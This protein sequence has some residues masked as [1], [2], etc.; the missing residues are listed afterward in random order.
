[1]AGGFEDF[2]EAGTVASPTDGGDFADFPEAGGTATTGDALTTTG[3][4]AVRGGLE[5]TG[6]IGGAMTGARLG[7][8]AAPFLGPLAPAAPIVGGVAGAAYGLYAGSEAASGLRIPDVEQLP[9]ALRP[10]GYAGQSLGGSLAFATAPYTAAVSGFRFAESMVGNYL[11]QIINTAKSSPILFGL[12][13]VTSAASAATAAGV[14][15]AVAPG[16]GGIRVTS[17][18]LGGALNPTRLMFDA[19]GYAWRRGKELA[20]AFSPAARE[21]A[22]GKMLSDIF[23]VTGEDPAQIAQVL[24]A[25]EKSGVPGTENLTGAQKTGSMGLAA[26]EEWLAKE[27]DRFGADAAQR[28]RDGMDA[29]R[30]QIALLTRTGDPAALQAAG[31]IQ[32]AYYRSLIQARLDAATNEAAQA[33]AKITKDTPAA[34]ADLSIVARNAVE[35]S[36]SAARKAEGELWGQVD[37]TRKV[38]ITNLQK[39]FNEIRANLLP[40]VRN[41]KTPSIV[42]DFIERTS[43]SIAERQSPILLPESLS[44][45]TISE[46]VGTTVKEM[47][48]LRSELLDLSR[49]STNAGEYG[50]ARI[51]SDLA[52]SVLDDM[53]TAFAQTGD[54]TYD[55]AR[56]FSRELNDTFTRSFAGRIMG[57]GRYGDRIAPELTLRKALA[58]GKEA[59]AIQLQEL[60]EAT[61]FMVT[62]GLGDDTAMANMLDAQERILRLAAAD[63][64]DPETGKVNTKSLQQFINNNEIL[65]NRFP[66][67]KRD[68]GEAVT[69]E[70]A[71]KRMESLAKGQMNIVEKQKTFS[72]VA[73]GDALMLANKALISLDQ[74]RELGNMIK[75][76]K[77][78]GKDAMDGLAASVFEAAITKS[79]NNQGV[80]D[81]ATMRSFLFDPTVPGKKSTM[82]LLQ[83]SGVVDAKQVSNI[84]KLFDA[85]ESITRAGQPGTAMDITTDIGDVALA[86]LSRMV[87]STV[88][89]GAARAAGSQTPSLVV[90]GAG[91]R[92]AETAMTKLPGTTVRKVLMEAM[93]DNDKLIM[94]LEKAPTPAKQAEQARRIHAWLVQSGLTGAQAAAEEY[95]P[96]LPEVIVTPET[97][98]QPVGE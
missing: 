82:Q 57:Q 85:A 58:S 75:V 62:R 25:L 69:S 81:V 93:V 63:T 4:Q 48:Q 29:I 26:L 15:E 46:P 42:R 10:F 19:A 38:G 70:Q 49:S 23:S 45:Q 28:A 17:E 95:L 1:M 41:Q 86:T 88:A 96:S 84:T 64:I 89:G 83:E 6:V 92:L 36:I 50:Q 34:R 80:L 43:K 22:A 20:S 76:A 74:E 35:Q 61:R 66:E 65:M 52:E 98:G 32:S 68:L 9:E 37:E 55:A 78:G 56:A 24:R 91:A 8:L 33:A 2:P 40:E 87:G 27:S 90:H 47:R 53:D 67:I 39:T 54:T 59:G 7:S 97:S 18:M 16:E 73:D 13:E 77:S 11:N 14:S 72:K 94:L 5:S 60:E 31:E 71:R 79:T 3:E 30:G 44:I 21:T 12:G 51:Y